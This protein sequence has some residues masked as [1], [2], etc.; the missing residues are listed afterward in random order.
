MTVLDELDREILGILSRD[1]RISYRDLGTR[2]SLSAN[3]AAER[4]RR[5]VRLGVITG[6]HAAVDHARVGRS[7]LALIGVRLPPSL[8]RTGFE[9]S[10]AEI[11]GV[12]SA[13]LM[14]GKSDYQLRVACKDTDDLDTIIGALRENTALRALRGEELLVKTCRHPRELR[15]RVAFGA[16]PR[17]D[18]SCEARQH[19]QA[20][21]GDDGARSECRRGRERGRVIG[22]DEDGDPFGDTPAALRRLRVGDRTPDDGDRRAESGPDRIGRRDALVEPGKP[23]RE[24]R[25]RLRILACGELGVRAVDG[26]AEGRGLPAD[27]RQVAIDALQL[28][29]RGAR[30]FGRAL[31]DAR[32]FRDLR[33]RAREIRGDAASFALAFAPLLRE[34]RRGRG[35]LLVAPEQ[36]P[37]LVAKAQLVALAVE[38]RALG[39]DAGGPSFC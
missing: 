37:L 22:R 14:T 35:E 31:R 3:A 36:R 10:I 29:A 8:S 38:M 32:H 20:A 26:L 28:V 12:L 15:G 5:L 30:A 7:L 25:E 4:L 39:L 13:T 33:A 24:R 17:V 2:V 19:E 23:F 9:S 6:F 11:P 34:L 27:Q 18:D 1:G 21:R 16:A